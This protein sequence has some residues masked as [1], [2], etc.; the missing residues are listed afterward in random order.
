MDDA[1]LNRGLRKDRLDRPRKALQAVDDGDQDVL[2]AAGLQL[3]HHL[4][5]EFG[6]F[7]RLDPE[8]ENVLRP[9]CCDPEREID[10]LVADQAF[11]ANLT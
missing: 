4:E 5:P 7:G 8:P 1:G 10:G 3:V 9:I 6:A 2:D 11:V